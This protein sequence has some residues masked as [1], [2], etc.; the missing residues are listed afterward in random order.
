MSAFELEYPDI[1]T[2]IKAEYASVADH[3]EMVTNILRKFGAIYDSPPIREF[4]T[5]LNESIDP[6]K[7]RQILFA[8]KLEGTGGGSGVGN[9]MDV[10]DADVNLFVIGLGNECVIDSAEGNKLRSLLVSLIYLVHR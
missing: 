10:V 6:R 1:V 3:E 7:L 5:V 8:P 4:E 9:G 2:A